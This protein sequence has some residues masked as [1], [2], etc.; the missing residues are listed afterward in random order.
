MV[1][2]PVRRRGLPPKLRELVHNERN[3][4]PVLAVQGG[5]IDLPF[6]WGGDQV[7]QTRVRSRAF[8]PPPMIWNMT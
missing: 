7:V 1:H 5:L 8:H 2:P 6:P 3:Q 4:P